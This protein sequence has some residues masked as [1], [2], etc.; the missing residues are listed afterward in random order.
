MIYKVQANSLNATG[1][2]LLD[3]EAW[4]Y[5]SENNVIINTRNTSTYVGFWTSWLY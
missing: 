3:T 1:N 4:T 2:A 5:D